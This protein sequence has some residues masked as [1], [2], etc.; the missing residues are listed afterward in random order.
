MELLWR[1]NKKCIALHTSKIIDFILISTEYYIHISEGSNMN[2]TLKLN[3]DGIIPTDE[4]IEALEL[5]IKHPLPHE[6]RESYLKSDIQ[7]PRVNVFPVAGEDRSQIKKF[8]ALENLAA[9]YEQSVNAFEDSNYLPFA[10]CEGGDYVCIN[11]MQNT[12]EYGHIYFIDHEIGEFEFTCSS[13]TA[14]LSTVK[15]FDVSNLDFSKYQ[16]EVT[17]TKEAREL[18][19]YKG[20]K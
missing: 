13:I 8:I 5:E 14:F 1:V 3:P 16:A 10:Q 18:Q 19:S 6:F 15:L 20:N 11:I 12:P 2:K 4:E 9:V 17:L 7:I